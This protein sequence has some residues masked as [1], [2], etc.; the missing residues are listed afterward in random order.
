MEIENFTDRYQVFLPDDDL[1]TFVKEY[2]IFDLKKQP[3]VSVNVGELM[4]PLL[5]PE[6]IFKIGGDYQNFCVKENTTKIIS[7]STIC[8]IQ[9]YAKASK[10]VN[11][12]ERLLLIGIT[13]EYAGMYQ[14]L[15]LPLIE[16]CDESI[17]I[18]EVPNN[19]LNKLELRLQESK[20]A[21]EIVSILNREFIQ[22]FKNSNIDN[23]CLR[24][25]NIINSTD[26]NSLALLL[27]VSQFNY[28]YLERRFKKYIGITPKK[29]FKLK[30]YLAFY[31]SWLKHDDYNYVDLV[32]EFGFFDQNHL[33]KDFKSVLKHSPNQFKKL[34][35][36][37]FT[38]YIT[39]AKLG[40]L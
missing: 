10:R 14:V 31:E 6:I 11:L 38:D 39:L 4:Q 32:Y 25:T 28:K 15:N 27:N 30:R 13:F 29:Y 24:F 37:N 23:E 20:N 5:F 12:K 22:Y 3:T 17:S 8:G 2:W 21:K 18:K 1:K 19:F 33:I 7:S 26:V 9:K 16:F 34:K 35:A 40:L 36:E